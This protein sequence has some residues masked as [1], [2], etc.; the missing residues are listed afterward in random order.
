MNDFVQR[1]FAA[2]EF[3]T[4]VPVPARKNFRADDL[5]K[6]VPFFPL[7]GLLVAAGGLAL[8]SVLSPHASRSVVVVLILIYLVLVTGALHEDAL[9]DAADGFGGGWDKEQVL[10]IMRDSRIGSYGALAISLSLLARFVFLTELAPE[11]FVGYFVAGQVLSR[12]TALPLSF[13]LPS[14]RLGSGQGILVAKKISWMSLVSGTLLAVAISAVFL[15]YAAAWAGLSALFIAAITGSF[16][17]WRIGGIT[18]DCLGATIQ[19]A[20]VGVYLT[21]VVVR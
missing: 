17:R 20:E 15:E 3:L 2:T 13:F 9:A 12:W 11:K 5:A 10:A 1:F 4:R 21:G 16:Y 14:A 6:S 7:I 19:L 18:G 8:H